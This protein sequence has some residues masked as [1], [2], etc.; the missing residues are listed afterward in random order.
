M[1]IVTI[2]GSDHRA[3][4]YDRTTTAFFEDQERVRAE[5]LGA[6]WGRR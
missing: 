2:V 6:G 3:G 4:A 1:E 5:M